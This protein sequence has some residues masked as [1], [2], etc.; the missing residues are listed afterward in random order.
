MTNEQK[1]SVMEDDYYD[2][3]DICK[4]C[5]ADPCE[6]DDEWDEHEHDM[7]EAMREERERD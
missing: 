6:C 3:P 5:G 1:L 2:I 7:N 4:Q